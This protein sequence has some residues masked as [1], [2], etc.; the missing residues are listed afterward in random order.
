MLG[1]LGRFLG[2]WLEDFLSISEKYFP[3]K[4]RILVDT[5]MAQHCSFATSATRARGSPVR[6]PREH[7]SH[8]SRK[9]TNLKPVFS[10]DRCR[11]DD[12]TSSGLPK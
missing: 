9:I 2:P 12:M 7:G 6:T 10:V 8:T 4:P 1:I 11:A 3:P 5:D